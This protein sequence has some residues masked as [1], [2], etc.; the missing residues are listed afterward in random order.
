MNFWF[1]IYACS[2]CTLTSQ[3]FSILFFQTSVSAEAALTHTVPPS[4]T[5]QPM[6]LRAQKLGHPRCTVKHGGVSQH[7]WPC[8]FN[9]TIFTLEQVRM[10]IPLPLEPKGKKDKTCLE[11]LSIA[12]RTSGHFTWAEVNF[13]T[14]GE[15]AQVRKQIHSAGFA[16]S[17]TWP[18][19]GLKSQE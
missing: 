18:L 2:H 14:V 19:R 7:A 17:K 13:M 10:N 11:G 1:Y 15:G 9:C 12:L 6:S 8:P 3:T 4:P 16:A 5:T